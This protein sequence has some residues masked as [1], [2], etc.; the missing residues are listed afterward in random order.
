MSSKSNESKFYSISL[1][2]IKGQKGSFGIST[3]HVN[4]KR[5]L[6]FPIQPQTRM[7]YVYDY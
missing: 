7:H 6:Y 1:I 4:G 5:Q 3:N 2:P